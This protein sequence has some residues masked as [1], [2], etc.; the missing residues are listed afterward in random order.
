MEDAKRWN[1][2]ATQQPS[3]EAKELLG[4]FQARRITLVTT[5]DLAVINRSQ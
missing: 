1:R 4:A 5:K 2:F 3:L